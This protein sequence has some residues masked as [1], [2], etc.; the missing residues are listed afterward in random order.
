MMHKESTIPFKIYCIKNQRYPLKF[1]QIYL[2][3]LKERGEKKEKKKNSLFQNQ[4]F[5]KR[6]IIIII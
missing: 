4:F 3:N 6:I 2:Y 1:T 5:V